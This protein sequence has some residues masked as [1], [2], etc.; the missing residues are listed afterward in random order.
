M[1]G[2]EF[3]VVMEGMESRR[4]AGQVA[5]DLLKLL[6]QPI[7]MDDLQLNVTASIGISF[8]PEDGDSADALEQCAD[9]A[10]YKAKFSGVGVRSFTDGL[11]KKYME[12]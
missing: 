6:S 8:Y 4:D 7:V 3:M 2:D 1:G 11:S 9:Q 5:N 12:E 10:M